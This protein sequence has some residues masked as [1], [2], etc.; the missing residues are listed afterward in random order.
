MH[1]DPV[2]L[3]GTSFSAA[4]LLRRL[5]AAGLRVAVCGNLPDDPCVSWA[6]AYFEIDYSDPAALRDLV[7]RERF[8][9]ICPSC[10]DAGY[11]A[12][13]AVAHEFGYPG[14]DTP[15][16]TAILHDKAQF[17]AFAS[18]HGLAVP[19]STVTAQRSECAVEDLRLPLL[20][21]PT[22]ASGGRGVVRVDRAEDLDAAIATAR[23]ASRDGHYVVESFID[24]TLHSHSSFLVDSA[25]VEEYFV[26]EFCTVYPY[27]VNCSNSPSRL[28]P[29]MRRKA[30]AAVSA[31]VELLHPVDGLLHTQFMVRGTEVF[32]IECMRRCP[33]DLYPQLIRH[34]SHAAYVD[35][36]LRPFLGRPIDARQRTAFE[37][38]AR[39]TISVPEARV[40]ASFRHTIPAREVE[41]FALRESGRLIERA[42]FDKVAIV[43]ARFDSEAELFAATPRLHEMMILQ[44]ES[45]DDAAIR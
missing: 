33:G 42:P 36:Y 32:L 18:R 24:G 16:T 17:R 21:K 4:P 40:V 28:S 6:D 15:S 19:W 34:S 12:A 1:H 39:H 8:A 27:Q 30:R 35:N 13:A 41:I 11:L 29:D 23:A 38:W 22:D 9:A 37:P 44:T 14:Y 31:L 45:H 20:V 3:L 10:N 26:D 43:F 7:T 2:L 25:I 5:Q